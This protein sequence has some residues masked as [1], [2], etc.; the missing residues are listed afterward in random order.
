MTKF[1]MIEIE[2]EY[3]DAPQ[4]IVRHVADILEPG[5]SEGVNPTFEFLEVKS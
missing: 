3:I 1:L 2:D 5:Y 4:L